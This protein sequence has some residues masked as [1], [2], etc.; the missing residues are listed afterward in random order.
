MKVGDVFL[1]ENAIGI[2]QR[3]EVVEMSD[4]LNDI[5]GQPVAVV[6]LESGAEM[7][8]TQDVIENLPMDTQ[9]PNRKEV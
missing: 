3:L 9:S 1:Y 7:V 8:L 2:T 6:M 5:Y 4:S